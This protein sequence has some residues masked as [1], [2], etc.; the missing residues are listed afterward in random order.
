MIQAS[1][2][3]GDVNPFSSHD[4]DDSR[5]RD[6]GRVLPRIDAEAF[7]DLINEVSLVFDFLSRFK[8][9]ICSR[10]KQQWGLVIL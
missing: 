6:F 4:D 5:T 1:I 2:E 7:E 8:L 3:I 10:R 9:L